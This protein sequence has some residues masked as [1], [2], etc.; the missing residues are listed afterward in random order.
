MN[1]LQL[2]LEMFF[3]YFCYTLYKRWR[4]NPPLVAPL[5]PP[6][7]QQ[8]PYASRILA[9]FIPLGYTTERGG[10]GLL[11]DTP[12]CNVRDGLVPHSWTRNETCLFA[13]GM[14]L[15]TR[16]VECT[17]ALHL[18]VGQLPWPNVRVVAVDA[19]MFSMDPMKR[20]FT[21]TPGGM[22]ATTVTV[23]VNERACIVDFST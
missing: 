20:A 2:L 14:T 12:L 23:F 4:P 13:P 17:S 10:P 21:W 7:P 8:H 11:A 1:L 3:V 5:P 19:A 6:L 16:T 9:A 22:H 15:V 18:W